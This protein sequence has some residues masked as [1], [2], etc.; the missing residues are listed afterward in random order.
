MISSYLAMQNAI[1]ARNVATS[2]MVC[3]SANMM[4][5]LS[6]GNSQPLKPSFAQADRF[7]LQNKANETK[8]SFLAK[9][10]ATHMS[11]EFYEGIGGILFDIVIYM[12][13]INIVL[14]I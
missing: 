3:N 8:V 6:F 4:S 9:Y 7:E 5:S 1:L 13:G 2:Q 14:M 12:V 10:M 11:M